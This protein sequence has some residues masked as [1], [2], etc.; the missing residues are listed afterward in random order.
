MRHSLMPW[1]VVALAVMIV[2]IASYAICRATRSSFC[3]VDGPGNPPV[4]II[5]YHWEVWWE[6]TLFT[7]YKPL[8]HLDQ[9][10][11]DTVFMHPAEGDE[12]E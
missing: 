3:P 8:R 11:F 5:V 7:F 1:I 4:R 2:Y 10:L 12:Y 6:R 9:T